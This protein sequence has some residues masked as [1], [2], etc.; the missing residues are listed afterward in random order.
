[1][2]FIV[3]ER[4]AQVIERLACQSDPQKR[5]FTNARSKSELDYRD[6]DEL[7]SKVTEFLDRFETLS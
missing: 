1:M 7:I 5:L 2:Q 4:R 6:S 3:Q